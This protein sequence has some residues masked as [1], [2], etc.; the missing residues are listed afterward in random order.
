MWAGVQDILENNRMEKTQF[1]GDICKHLLASRTQS[2]LIT[3][4]AVTP[5]A[6]HHPY[7]YF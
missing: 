7:Y 5:E 2:N 4:H 3:I 6:N 1:M